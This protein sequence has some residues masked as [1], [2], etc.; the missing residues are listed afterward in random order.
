MVAINNNL[1]IT[2]G[3]RIGIDVGVARIGV[4]R[5]DPDGILALPFE[6]VKADDSA[7]ARILEIIHE[8]DAHAIYVGLPIS[9]SGA[10]T[11]STQL[12]KDFAS[13]LTSMTTAPVLLIDERLSTKSAASQLRSAGRN[14]KN[15]KEIID[16]AAAVVIL[17]SALEAERRT[18]LRA[19]QL[20]PKG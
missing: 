11:S 7:L 8:F 6:T 19:G 20:V 12:A 14:A 5:T 3:V 13:N 17:E 10:D 9:L 4:A 16:Q 1:S 2:R 18:Q 15:S